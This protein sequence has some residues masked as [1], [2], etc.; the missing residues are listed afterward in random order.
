MHTVSPSDCQMGYV[1]TLIDAF[2]MT[3][4]FHPH[5]SLTHPLWSW[6]L[7]SP[8]YSGGHTQDTTCS[9]TYRPTINSKSGMKS[10]LQTRLRELCKEL[11]TRYSFYIVTVNVLLLL[12][13]IFYGGKK[14]KETNNSNKQTNRNRKKK[15]PTPPKPTPKPLFL[16]GNKHRSLQS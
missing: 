10:H 16:T 3:Y 7:C 6:W 12:Y 11:L 5:Y 1:S 13:C 15:K 2:S 8:V 14:K 4:T 9:G